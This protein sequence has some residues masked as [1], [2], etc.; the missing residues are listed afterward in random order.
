MKR[1]NF[2]SRRYLYNSIELHFLFISCGIQLVVYEADMKYV[3]A[4][5]NGSDT[6]TEEKSIER[7]QYSF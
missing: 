4:E 7:V 6:E 3:Y 5:C 2:E 1:D